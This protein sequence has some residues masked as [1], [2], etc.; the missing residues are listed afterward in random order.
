MRGRTEASASAETLPERSS[1]FPGGTCGGRK[2]PLRYKMEGVNKI[3]INDFLM[4]EMM[5]S[6][7]GELMMR[8]GFLPS[9]SRTMTSLWSFGQLSIL[10]KTPRC[11]AGSTT[12][13][14][15]STCKLIAVQS[16]KRSELLKRFLTTQKSIV[17]SFTSP[18]N[19][20]ATKS[21]TSRPTING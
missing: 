6:Q 5:A 20:H 16:G 10:K 15:H 13:R 1:A 14:R 3:A 7:L 8:F 21:P 19:A 12:H 9:L 18:F 4:V 17:Q 2:M 11:G